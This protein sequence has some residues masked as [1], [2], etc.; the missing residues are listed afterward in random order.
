MNKFPYDSYKALID[1]MEAQI[2]RLESKDESNYTNEDVMYSSFELI[3]LANSLHMYLK[4]FKKR[5]KR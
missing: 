2:K 5:N 1:N 4:H 3:S